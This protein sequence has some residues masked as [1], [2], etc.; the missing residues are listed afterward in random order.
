M[1]HDD[2][3]YP[4]DDAALWLRGVGHHPPHTSSTQ[5]STYITPFNITGIPATPTNGKRG[6][7]EGQLIFAQ[8]YFAKVCVEN[9]QPPPYSS[10]TKVI[11][12]HQ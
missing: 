2:V 12:E 6:R 11:H 7:R 4:G 9:L 10:S 5:H 3:L 8:Q 1:V